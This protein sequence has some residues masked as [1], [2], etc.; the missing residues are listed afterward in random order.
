MFYQHPMEEG[1]NLLKEATTS[2]PNTTLTPLIIKDR[3]IFFGSHTRD[4]DPITTTINHCYL[5]N[6][7]SVDVR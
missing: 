1:E 7:M 4:N 2:F 6:F 5:Y 3:I